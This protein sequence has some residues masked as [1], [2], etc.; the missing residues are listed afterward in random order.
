M[1]KFLAFFLM[2]FSCV[3]AEPWLVYGTT[4]V[5][6]STNVDNP[7]P[8][9][10]G[11][12]GEIVHLPYIV[13]E[14]YHLVITAYAIEGGKTPQYA[15]IP[16]IGNQ[17]VQNDQCLMTCAAAYGSNLYSGMEWI[18]PS[19]KILNIRISNSGEDGLIY[20]FGWYMQG[21]LI[22]NEGNNL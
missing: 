19:G 16:W 21:Y 8:S 22:K 20:A 7:L 12:I 18:I 10:N 13:P 9:V 17:P 1:I 2:L 6:P 11:L 3:S 5:I 15:L 4:E 14:G